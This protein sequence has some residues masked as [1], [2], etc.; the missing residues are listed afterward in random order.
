MTAVGGT[1]TRSFNESRRELFAVD[2]F[3]L[4]LS[5]FEKEIDECQRFVK[6]Q[7]NRIY[8]RFPVIEKLLM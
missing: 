6:C 1:M 2:V 5:V 4:S 7:E 3:G 8:L